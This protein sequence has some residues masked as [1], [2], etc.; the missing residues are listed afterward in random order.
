MNARSM[1]EYLGR[2]TGAQL[3]MNAVL[4]AILRRY[5]DGLEILREAAESAWAD[6]ANLPRGGDA[7]VIQVTSLERALE[8]ALQRGQFGH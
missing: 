4:A 7:A 5:P 1:E 3:L 8:E 2:A 6:A